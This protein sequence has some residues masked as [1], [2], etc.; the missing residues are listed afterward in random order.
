MR[1]QHN[2]LN[3]HVVKAEYVCSVDECCARFRTYIHYEKHMLSHG[4]EIEGKYIFLF[5][6]RDG[7]PSVA[8]DDIPI[9]ER[10]AKYEAKV[11]HMNSPEGRKHDYL[12]A[13]F[14][15]MCEMIK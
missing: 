12:M 8:I 3:T 11:Q 15:Q 6:V 14:R 1:E 9:S 5:A 10:A 2:M 7:V 4:K 13:A